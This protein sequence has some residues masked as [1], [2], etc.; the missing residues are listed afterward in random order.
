MKFPVSFYKA[1]ALC[2]IASALTTLM[3]IFLPRFYGPAT[4]FDHRL[5]LVHHPLYQLR[6]WAYLVHPFLVLTAALRVAAALRRTA[7]GAVAAG[8]LGFVLWA[9][10]EAAQ[11]TL[12][13]TA[14]RRWAAAFAL[15]TPPLER[16]CAPTSPPT[17]PFGM[18][19][20]S[21]C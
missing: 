21:C 19:C 13:L 7:P 12:T 18:R 2:S 15:R 20:S 6:A 16:P 8:F 4:S 11:Q 10:T 5:E 3:L 1:A 9:F 17:T 14:F